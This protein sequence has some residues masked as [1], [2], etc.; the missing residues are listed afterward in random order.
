MPTG[1]HLESEDK[2][3]GEGREIRHKEE[4]RLLSQHRSD[5]LAKLLQTWGESVCR[6]LWISKLPKRD[7]VSILNSVVKKGS[8][9]QGR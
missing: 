4:R 1:G 7:C 3:Q 2:K 8:G 6:V 9:A 5:F